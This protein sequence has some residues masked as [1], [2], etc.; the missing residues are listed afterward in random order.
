L[1]R[2]PEQWY[3]FKFFLCM[4]VFLTSSVSVADEFANID[5]GN[6][7]TGG[8]INGGYSTYAVGSLT[9]SPLFEYFLLNRFA[10]GVSAYYTTSPALS[11][12]TVGPIFT[13][14]FWQNEKWTAYCEQRF[15][16]AFSTTTNSI[17]SSHTGVGINYFFIRQVSLGPQIILF[18]NLNDIGFS[19]TTTATFSIYF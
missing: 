9:F 17:W 10:L 1:F 4:S 14:Y 18:K 15:A 11:S 2:E 13:Y 6:Y 19:F 5:R 12:I 8:S 3:R 16:Y 7:R